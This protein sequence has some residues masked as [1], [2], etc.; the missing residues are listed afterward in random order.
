MKKIKIIRGNMKL[1]KKEKTKTQQRAAMNRAAIKI[2][3]REA[4]EE[5]DC[6]GSCCFARF[7]RVEG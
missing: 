7:R 6:S 2:F 5:K 3:R 1:I 4:H